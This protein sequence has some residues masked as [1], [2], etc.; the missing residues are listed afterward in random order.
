MVYMKIKLLKNI[1]NKRIFKGIG[2]YPY[3]YDNPLLI[4]SVI[5]ELNYNEVSNRSHYIIV[6][7]LPDDLFEE[8]FLYLENIVK[9][10]GLDYLNKLVNNWVSFVESEYND[11]KNNTELKITNINFRIRR[12]RELLVNEDLKN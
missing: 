12:I 2:G 8:Y 9:I 6:S 5:K 4:F 3:Y 1:F 11:W 10:W 7:G